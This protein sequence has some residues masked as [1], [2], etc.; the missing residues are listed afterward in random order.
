MWYFDGDALGFGVVVDSVFAAFSA[1]A[2]HLEAAK[3]RRSVENV[4]AVDPHVTSADPLRQVHR[5]KR[6]ER[7]E[8]VY[9]SV[10]MYECNFLRDSVSLS[11]HYEG[12]S[13]GKEIGKS[14]RRRGRKTRGEEGRE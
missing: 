5:L 12:E 8:G 11:N 7:D 14:K 9:R 2:G 4:V 3:R 13:R 10:R 1:V 6:A